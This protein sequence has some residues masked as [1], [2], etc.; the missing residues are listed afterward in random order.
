MKKLT[1]AFLA[2][3]SMMALAFAQDATPTA[4]GA[5]A[6]A[7]KAEEKPFQKNE[8]RT[9]MPVAFGL[10]GQKTIDIYGVRF[11]IGSHCESI[12]GMDFSIN[13]DATNAY[14]IQ[15]AL[16]RNNVEDRAGALQIAIGANYAGS[17]A[18][19]QIGFW[20]A[21]TTARGIQVGLVNS[22]SDVRGFQVG[23][24]NTTE[25]I[26][27][28]QIGIINVIRGSFVPFFPGINFMLED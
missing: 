27:G 2:S 5:E 25:M 22:A 26:Y 13:G 8:T 6:T 15:L 28:Y 7:P 17:L 18:G 14:G 12:T 20:N 10:M 19:A 3:L 16:F 1:V 4:S 11:N 24:V 9:V 23:L 21:A